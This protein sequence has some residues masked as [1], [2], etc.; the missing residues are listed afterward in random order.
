MSDV[1]AIV[2]NAGLFTSAMV[3]PLA[4]P[5]VHL[6]LRVWTVDD[7]D[8]RPYALVPEGARGTVVFICPI[9][10][11]VEIELDAEVPGLR[12]WGNSF[13]LVPFETEELMSAIRRFPG[14]Q[15]SPSVHAGFPSQE[16]NK[17]S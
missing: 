8:L 4:A 11:E 7:I 17:C 1:R 3:S 15:T 14:V 13:S 12:S 10:G 9:S 16:V 2:L 5:S 6:G